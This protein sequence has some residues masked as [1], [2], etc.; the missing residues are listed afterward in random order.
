LNKCEKKED[1][2]RMGGEAV[3]G[4]KK[5]AFQNLATISKLEARS[6]YEKET[7][8]KK[9]KRQSGNNQKAGRELVH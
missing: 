9:E 7:S 8:C 6:F 3:F 4:T 1:M 2:D 5:I